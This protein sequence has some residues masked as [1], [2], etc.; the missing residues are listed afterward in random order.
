MQ[1]CLSF[2]EIVLE[3]LSHVHGLA[4]Q[5]SHPLHSLTPIVPPLRIEM[6]FLLVFQAPSP[7]PK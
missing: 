2:E 7:P 4:F 5:L 6:V 3:E 1:L